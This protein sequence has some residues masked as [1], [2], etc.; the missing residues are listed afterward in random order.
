[1]LRAC[2]DA[3]AAVVPQGGNTGLVGGS[4]P[5]HGEIVLDLRRL[6]ALGSGRRAR[7]AGDRAGRRDD[8]AAPRRTRAPRVGTTASTSS[9][10]DTATV[11]GTVAT[12]AGGMHVLRYG[13]TR[14]QVLGVEAV[15]A[16]GRVDA[17][18]RRAR[19]G[20]HRLRPRRPAVRERGHARRHHR[21]PAAARA[22][23]RRT[24]WSRCSRST[25]SRPRSTRSASSGGR[26]T[27][28]ERSSCSSRTGSTSCASGSGSPGR[29]R[30]R[31]SRSCSSRRPRAPIRPPSSPHAIDALAGVAD[32]AVAADDRA[33]R[34]LWR[35][36]EGHTE[37]INLLGAPHKLDVTLPADQ[38][39]GFVAE[40]REHV[41]PVAPDA[42]VWLFGHAADGNIHVNVTGVA[43]DDDRITD[44]V[45]RLV[46]RRHGSISAEHGIGTAKRAWLS[47]VRSPAEIDAFR[48]IKRALDPD[49]VLN[50][51]VLLPSDDGRVISTPTLQLD[52]GHESGKTVGTFCHT[53]PRRPAPVWLARVVGWSDRP[54]PSGD[55]STYR[56]TSETRKRTGVS[57][58]RYDRMTHAGSLSLWCRLAEL[59]DRVHD[60]EAAVVVDRHAGRG[61]RRA[62]LDAFDVAA[63]EEHDRHPAGVVDER[64]LEAR[65]AGERLDAHRLH[66]AVHAHLLAPAHRADRCRAV[67]AARRR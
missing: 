46:A 60:G 62:D 38:L 36:R 49:N 67:G 4:V 7:R 44:A 43:P 15:F 55:P 41:A 29:S 9:A 54:P 58:G 24:S 23:A 30:R 8:R 56:N 26:S 61:E 12:N 35:Y 20:Q 65:A 51:H 47:L 25:T 52:S 14:R 59:V 6:D 64:A 42:A 40:V 50:P 31:T 10:R 3:G 57:G 22:P 45:L 17:P 33:A 13:S 19:E 5:L 28:S 63:A 66:A 1:M 16:D 37:A 53:G 2:G 32:V 48:A 34:D 39:A 27:R 11:G 21:G 18:P